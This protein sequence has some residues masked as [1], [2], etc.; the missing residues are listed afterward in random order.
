MRGNLLPPLG[1][2]YRLTARVHLYASPTDRIP[3][4]TAFVTPVMEHW[5]KREIAHW[6][7]PMKEDSKWVLDSNLFYKNRTWLYQQ[8]ALVSFNK[9]MTIQG[10]SSLYYRSTAMFCQSPPGNALSIALY[11]CC[12]F[13]SSRTKKIGV[14]L[15]H[16]LPASLG[17]SKNSEYHQMS[18]WDGPDLE[19]GCSLVVRV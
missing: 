8:T 9:N 6:V 15:L 14:I 3:H 17:R 19:V 5:L 4:T 18:S 13:T 16:F 2:S 11:C 7:Y 12:C 10:T 1:Y